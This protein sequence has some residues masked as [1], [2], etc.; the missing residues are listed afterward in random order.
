MKPATFLHTLALFV[1]AAVMG[2]A[3]PTTPTPPDTAKRS[4]VS[5]GTT[6]YYYCPATVTVPLGTLN[7]ISGG[8]LLGLGVC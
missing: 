2:L 6:C 4:F 7:L 5:A 3:A 1:V 8:S